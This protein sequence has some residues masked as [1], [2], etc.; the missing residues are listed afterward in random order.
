[1]KHQLL[2]AQSAITNDQE[3]VLGNLEAG[4]VVDVGPGGEIW[5]RKVSK[6]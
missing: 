5:G 6:P 3:S 2:L 4:V 1:M